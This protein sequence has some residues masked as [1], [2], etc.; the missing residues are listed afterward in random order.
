M[1][2]PPRPK[3]WRLSPRKDVRA[4]IPVTLGEK[5]CGSVAFRWIFPCLG[6]EKG[7]R[8][9]KAWIIHTHSERKSPCQKAVEKRDEEKAKTDRSEREKEDDNE[10]ELNIKRRLDRYSLRSGPGS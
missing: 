1:L 4:G 3:P 2:L 6:E 5:G 7:G 10:D 9:D 8:H